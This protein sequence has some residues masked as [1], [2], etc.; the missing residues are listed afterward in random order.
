MELIAKACATKR[1]FNVQEVVYNNMLQ[2]WLR[3]IFP[4]IVSVTTNLP[5][6][7]FR[8]WLSEQE[9]KELLDRSTEVFKKNMVDWYKDRQIAAFQEGKYLVIDK[10]RHPEFLRYHFLKNNIKLSDK[11]PE[12][13]TEELV[14][15]NHPSP[16]LY[17]HTEIL[18][19]SCKYRKVPFALRYHLPDKYILPGKYL[20]DL[21]FL[22]YLFR[23][24][25]ELKSCNLGIYTKRV[26]EVS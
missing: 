22:F 4:A 10:M 5:E 6:N 1:E 23:N 25:T 14:E 9:T 26:N 21:L 16:K 13:L 3:K 15:C 7:C 24:E 19:M 20:H 17:Y 2:L 8:V 12:E 18:L 11:Q